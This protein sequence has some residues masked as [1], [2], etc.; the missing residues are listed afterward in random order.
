MSIHVLYTNSFNVYIMPSFNIKFLYFTPVNSSLFL[1][2]IVPLR[3][4]TIFYYLCYL[5][6]L[7]N[8]NADGNRDKDV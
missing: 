5:Y 8:T 7:Y 4:F 2:V 1:F 3:I 6:Y